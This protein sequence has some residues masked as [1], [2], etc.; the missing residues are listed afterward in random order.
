MARPT[1]YTPEL[2]KKCWEYLKQWDEDGDVVPT[3]AA[4]CGY[5]EIN[6]DTFYSW[7]K[8]PEKHEFSDIALEIDRIQKRLLVNNGLLGT[9][10]S[11]ISA[12][13]L[14]NHGI[15]NKQH[16]DIDSENQAQPIKIQIIAED[17]KK[18]D[19]KS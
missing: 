9:F 5:I 2:L 12:I 10:T 11:K 18:T 16:I 3:D 19:N 8:D 13:M 15:I 17:A 14:S 6:L 7:V 1:K 4:L